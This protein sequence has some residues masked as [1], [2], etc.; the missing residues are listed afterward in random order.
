MTRVS[1]D[2]IRAGRFAGVFLVN[3]FL[4]STIVVMFVAWAMLAT[5]SHVVPPRPTRIAG[6]SA[7]RVGDMRTHPA[8]NRARGAVAAGTGGNWWPRD[9]C[10]RRDGSGHARC[11]SCGKSRYSA[12][13]GA[14]RL[15]SPSFER[16]SLWSGQRPIRGIMLTRGA[17]ML[18]LTPATWEV[19]KPAPGRDAR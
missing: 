3:L 6:T 16:R 11:A 7:A 17:S 10:P 14:Q 4:G 2:E 15:F 19:Y 13:F 9:G 12:H 5:P 8:R 1:G 18:L